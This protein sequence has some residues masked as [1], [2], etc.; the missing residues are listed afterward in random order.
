MKKAPHM[1][2]RFFCILEYFPDYISRHKTVTE[3]QPC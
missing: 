2:G 1:I 3:V